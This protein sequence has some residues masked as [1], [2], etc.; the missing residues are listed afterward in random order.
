MRC[1]RF[2]TFPN[3]AAAWA[4]AA[5]TIVSI[6][7]FSAAP[8][9]PAAAYVAGETHRTAD[10]PSAAVRDAQHRTALRITVWYP[11]AEG[12]V[13]QPLAIGD[14]QRPVFEA[15]S[16]A[17]NAPFAADPPG[18]RRAVILL[19][20][21]FGGTARIMG[22]FGTALA[23]TGY[24]VVSVDH[25]GNNGA[26]PMTV[27]G[28]ILWWERAEDLKRA[29][30]T[31]GDDKIIGPHVDIAQLGA[32]G[33]SAGG[34]TALVLGG[35]RADPERF[36]AF[37]EAHPDDGVC[38]PQ[39]EF[40]VTK[41]DRD[42]ALQDPQVAALEA[43]A[44]DDHSLAAVKAVFAIAPSLV[45]ALDPH[46]LEDLRRPTWIVAGNADT[47]ASPATNA[48][49]ATRLIPGARLDMLPQVGHYAFLSTCTPAA[50][51]SARQCARTGPQ[52][53]A[54]RLAIANAEEL[55][56]RYLGPP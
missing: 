41:A 47:V 51:A 49:V 37:C 10:Q 48:E 15:V 14:P 13:A 33:F 20:H 24:V 28:A 36:T 18:R 5:R 43:R 23:Q 45:Q 46:S 31:V 38:R 7:W 44:R 2:V 54:H 11:A 1:R 3:G 12:A 56:G 8:W 39:L 16:A 42:R 4:L 50:V 53:L 21:G 27:P 17:P 19:S 22:W 29:L 52:A 26:D 9:S 30:G 35:A 6:L 55:F 25:P 40:G 34:F 32:A